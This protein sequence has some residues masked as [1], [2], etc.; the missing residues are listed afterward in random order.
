MNMRK[1]IVASSCLLLLT[2]CF[3][4]SEEIWISEDGSGRMKLDIGIG[5]MLTKLVR[6]SGGTSPIEQL[7]KGFQD[8]QAQLAANPKITKIAY[9][10][11]DFGT[12]NHIVLDL[13]VTD[14]RLLTE[15][16]QKLMAQQRTQSRRFEFTESV[17][18]IAKLE[19]GHLGFYQKF[20]GV[21]KKDETEETDPASEV[22]G[23]YGEKFGKAMANSVLGDKF[24]SVKVHAPAISAT[25]GRLDSNQQSVEWRIPVLDVVGE[26][27]VAH[28]LTAEI[29]LPFNKLLLTGIIVGSVILIMAIIILLL[30]R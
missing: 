18:E 29:I 27:S 7:K 3:E 2:G 13:E 8:L 10:E 16:N 12:M 9:D 1:L 26:T 28:E 25:N 19:N 17:L 5:D 15:L 20:G 23:K 11:Y 22:I 4:F 14:A 30:R 6:E 21:H 24:I